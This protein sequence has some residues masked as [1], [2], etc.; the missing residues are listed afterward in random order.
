MSKTLNKNV[1][2]HMVTI[3][4]DLSITRQYNEND[5]LCIIDCPG[6]AEEEFHNSTGI[7]DCYVVYHAIT[8]WRLYIKVKTE[9][10][11]LKLKA[12]DVLVMNGSTC[13]SKRSND[14]QR[15]SFILCVLIRYSLR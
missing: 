13:H 6:S 8:T 10:I 4:N 11:L 12:G 14:T 1:K 7:K 3:L 5:V 15:T 2:E 9:S